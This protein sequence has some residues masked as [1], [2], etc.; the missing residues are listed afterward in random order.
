MLVLDYEV[1]RSLLYDLLL[2]GVAPV[3]YVFAKRLGRYMEQVAAWLAAFH[4]CNEVDQFDVQEQEISEALH[5]I[6]DM[7]E[8][9]S[10]ED[11]E[12]IR[13]HL[14][15]IKLSP[16]KRVYA[17][18]DFSPRNIL[19][20]KNGVTVVDWDVLLVKPV[21]YNLCYFMTNIEARAR[22]PLYSISFQRRLAGRFARRYAEC[23]GAGF[24]ASELKAYRYLYYIEYIHG[25]EH[26]LGVFEP[27]KENRRTMDMYMDQ[28]IKPQLRAGP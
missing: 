8:L 5:R 26:K 15:T 4:G 22:W 12:R 28:Y 27:W 10:R 1:G 17:N 24:D 13:S 20:T 23:V 11:K 21:Y 3:R 14:A 16:V 19:M 2:M 9:L 25:Y 6:E 7:R 18:H